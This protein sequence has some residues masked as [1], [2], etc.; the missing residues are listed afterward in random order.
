VASSQ[1]KTRAGSHSASVG[2]GGAGPWRRLAGLGRAAS[3]PQEIIREYFALVALIVLVIVATRLSSGFFTVSNIKDLLSSNAPTGFA[4]VGMT[5]VIITGAFDLSIGGIYALA[6][7]V[8]ATTAND[9]GTGVGILLGLVVGL[10]CGIINGFLV[11]VIDINSFIAT[12]GTGSVFS[13]AAY[14]YSHNQSISVIPASFGDL[15]IGSAAG[16]PISVW[17]LIGLF[18]VTWLVLRYT[19]FGRNLYATGGNREAARL[20]GI[21]TGGVQFTGFVV[22][23]LLAALAGVTFTSELATGQANIGSDLPLTVI[24]IVVIGG[25]SLFGGEGGLGRT[26]IGFLLISV[27]ID[28]FD[29]LALNSSLELVVEGAVLVLTVSMNVSYQFGSGPR[30]VMRAFRRLAAG[31]RRPSSAAGAR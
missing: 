11:G 9:Y 31:G 2:N 13:G 19:V 20:A 15:G 1:Q 14:L 26:L 27:L 6:A 29:L 22:V 23:G 25:T 3:S 16:L 5:M 28:V 10:V 18:V 8:S 17:V 30:A 4:C 12:L 21:R 7:V 24:A